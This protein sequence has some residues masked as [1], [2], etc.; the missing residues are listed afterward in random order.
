M[1]KDGLWSLT[2]RSYELFHAVELAV[3]LA[4]KLTALAS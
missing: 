4:V 3:K 1:W 2:G